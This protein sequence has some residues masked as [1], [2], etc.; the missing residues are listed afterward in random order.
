MAPPHRRSPALATPGLWDDLAR[1]GSISL[2]NNIAGLEAQRGR[3]IDRYGHEHSE[4]IFSNWTPAA[5]R[6]LGV[7]RVDDGGAA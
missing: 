7:R 1:S 6:A 3:L 2:P 4:A 5:I